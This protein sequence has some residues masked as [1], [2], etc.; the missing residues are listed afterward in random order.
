MIQ[1]S[2]NDANELFVNIA[3][4]LLKNGEYSSP[5]GQRTIELRDVWLTLEDP[6]KSVVTLEARGLD[7][8]YLTG[9]MEWYQSGSLDVKDIGK[10]SKF[11]FTLADPNGTVN[12]NYGFLAYKEKHNGRSQVEWCVSR[13]KS[14]RETR[15]AVI[16]YN[17]PRHK[18]D[19]NK[20]FVCTLNQ[21][22]RIRTEPGDRWQEQW[23][24]L[25]STT[26]MR[27]N[28]LIYGLSYDLPWFTGVQQDIA[29]KVGVPLGSYNH[30][31]ASLHVYEKHF[32]MLEAIAHSHELKGGQTMIEWHGKK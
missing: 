18:Y 1:I 30:F 31:A 17:Q 26:M 24:F 13:L 3:D 4:S 6:K 27:S 15:Q 14:D 23:V 9:E 19:D 29:E 10:H 12:S 16:N 25:D 21:L 20:D 11:W 2:G 22:F 8:D 5:R 7:M 28:D 32:E